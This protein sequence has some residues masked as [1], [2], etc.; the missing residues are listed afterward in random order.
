[1]K[2]RFLVLVLCL[3]AIYQVSFP[4][5][6]RQDL[7]KIDD[8]VSGAYTR[9]GTT[10]ISVAVVYDTVIIYNKAFGYA[11]ASNSRLATTSSLFNIASCSKAFTAA[12]VSILV[13][14]GK[15]RLTDKVRDYIPEFRL[16]DDYISRE[17]TIEDLLCHRSG[18]GTFF[19]DLLWYNTT[20]DNSDIIRRMQFLPITRRFGIEYGYQNNMFMVAGEIIR[21]V[22]GKSWEEF[23]TERILNPLSMVQTRPAPDMITSGQ[24]VAY[25][26]I[27]GET[28]PLYNFRATRPAA[29]MY[30]NTSELTRWAMMMINSGSLKGVRILSPAAVN[31]IMTPAIT[32]GVSQTQRQRETN[33]NS[34]GLGWFIYDHKGT[35]IVHHD[36]GM[37]GYISKVLLVPDKKYA[38][39]IL[40]N[41][42]DGYVNEA[43]KGDILDILLKGTDWDWT[44]EYLA[45]RDR[46]VA[47]SK[48]AD[49]ARASSR[50]TGTTPSLPLKD[51]SGLFR[52][53]MYGDAEVKTDGDKLTLTLLP[54][55]EVFTGTLEHWHYNTFK[56]V[57][58][59]KFLTYGLVTFSFNSSG[60]VE[61]FKIDLPSADFHFWNLDFK[62]VT[63]NR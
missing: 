48:R 39:I 1:M 10:G 63:T 29:S 30:S 32:L 28:L 59:D 14:E 52:D 43:V 60:I 6:S 36:G 38:V 13:D 41:G 58:R 54:A 16:Q 53:R 37:P 12:C 21:K 33:F 34:Y 18:L 2:K 47:A 23:L 17:M 8:I 56:V 5:L 11:D 15:I 45:A 22:T 55:S 35:R 31:K 27:N 44:G 57:F 20:Y 4:Q 40:N 62:K 46:S 3:A 9:F 61:G 50:V 51:Y 7:K 49:E 19:G 26:H 42:N 24:D 25:G